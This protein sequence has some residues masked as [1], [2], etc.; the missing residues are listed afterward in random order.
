MTSTSCISTEFKHQIIFTFTNEN[1]D[2][3]GMIYMDSSCSLHSF[4]YEP[5]RMSNSG[6]TRNYR[7]TGYHSQQQQTQQQQQRGDNHTN[8]LSRRSNHHAGGPDHRGRRGAGVNPFR[9][10]TQSDA[11]TGGKRIVLF[12]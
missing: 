4:S 2:V 5:D 1:N 3:H 9:I 8:Q 7:D 6:S 12:I 10:G 11:G